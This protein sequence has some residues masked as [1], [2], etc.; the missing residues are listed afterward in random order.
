MSDFKSHISHLTSHIFLLPAV[1]CLLL[2]VSPA[3]AAEEGGHESGGMI[4]RIVNFAILVAALFLIARYLKLKDFFTNRRE[5]IKFALEEAKKAKQEADEKVKEFELRLSLLN[6][7]IEEIYGEIRTEGEIEKKKIV[8]EAIELADRIKEQA[9]LAA[10]QEIKK[11]KEEIKGEIAKV[12]VEMAEEILRSE[13]TA[14]DHER[15]IKEYL[16]KVRLH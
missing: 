6:K 10:E 2:A 9:R 13:L 3:L 8:E 16:E 4:W 15:L 12:A 11:A 5:S 7:K 14:A 1:Y